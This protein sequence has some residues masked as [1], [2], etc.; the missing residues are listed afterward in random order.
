MTFG[1]LLHLRN[2]RS[3]FHSE[4]FDDQEFESSMVPI[5]IMDILGLNNYIYNIQ[6]LLPIVMVMLIIFDLY[7][8]DYNYNVQWLLNNNSQFMNGDRIFQLLS[9][10]MNDGNHGF[11]RQ[12]QRYDYQ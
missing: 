8:N 4:R 12:Q 6:I 11:Q 2:F 10:I 1:I 7:L 3:H 5:H 9:S